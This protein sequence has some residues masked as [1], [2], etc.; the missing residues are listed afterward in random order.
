MPASIRMHYQHTNFRLR[1]FRRIRQMMPVIPRQRRTQHHQIEAALA[2]RRFHSL[3][4]DSLL[5]LVTSLLKRRSRRRLRLRI[6]FA[7]KNL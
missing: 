7:I 1:L 2:N 6:P 3:A 4:A 5:H